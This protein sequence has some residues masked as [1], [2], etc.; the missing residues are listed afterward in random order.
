MA[1]V[2]ATVL[3]G[4]HKA[5]ET[6]RPGQDKMRATALQPGR[7][8][9]PARRQRTGRQAARPI[10][11]RANPKRPRGRIHGRATPR[12]SVTSSAAATH[13]P[14]PTVAGRAW[15]AA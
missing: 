11:R 5:P 12:P 9:A 13:A 14:T 2:L 7:A 8:R 10:A 1:N 4:P 6:E 3:H 15:V